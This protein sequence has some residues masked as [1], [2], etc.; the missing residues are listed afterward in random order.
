V[1]Y[2]RYLPARAHIRPSADKLR[3]EMPLSSHVI[4]SQPL[5]SETLKLGAIATGPACVRSGSLGPCLVSSRL[6]PGQLSSS[7]SLASCPSSSQS[8]ASVGPKCLSSSLGGCLCLPL[9]P[10]GPP[11]A[12]PAAIAWISRSKMR[13]AALISALTSSFPSPSRAQRCALGRSG[14]RSRERP[15]TKASTVGRRHQAR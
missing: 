1:L 15:I 11:Q 8:P 2:P 5:M 3:L 13:P 14:S 4:A 6:V 7:Q 9:P 12:V 10:A